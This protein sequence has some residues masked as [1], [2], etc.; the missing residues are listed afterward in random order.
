MF[1]QQLFSDSLNWF[2]TANAFLPFFKG[3][4]SPGWEVSEEHTTT[5]TLSDQRAII[6]KHSALRTDSWKQKMK[7]NV[8]TGKANSC[9][10]PP[11]AFRDWSHE[12]FLKQKRFCREFSCCNYFFSL[13]IS[14]QFAHPQKVPATT[15]LQEKSSSFTVC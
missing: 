13:H 2:K 14:C 6:F 9:P 1:K 12:D 4:L 5:P 7:K 11:L 15:I 3:N 10:S 8:R